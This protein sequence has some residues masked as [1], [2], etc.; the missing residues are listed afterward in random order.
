MA[1]APLFW[2]SVGPENSLPFLSLLEGPRADP[3]E[4]PLPQVGLSSSLPP[5]HATSPWGALLADLAE[6]RAL[7]MPPASLLPSAARHTSVARNTGK[8]ASQPCFTQRSRETA[9]L[10]I[11]S[12]VTPVGF[13]Q[14]ESA[15]ARSQV[16][17][18]TQG[19]S[20][21]GRKLQP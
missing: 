4:L 13:R 18:G 10:V 2:L 1:F 20:P 19:L 6:S 15:L 12:G 11:K 9:T 16:P 21:G 3:W 14:E 8:A 7:A 5:P 17:A